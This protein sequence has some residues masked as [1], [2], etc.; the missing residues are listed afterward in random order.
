[1]VDNIYFGDSKR[2]EDSGDSYQSS[3]T[4]NYSQT[5]DTGSQSGNAFADLGDDDGELP[6]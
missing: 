3:Y 1:M 5:Q 2:K 6:F 4:G